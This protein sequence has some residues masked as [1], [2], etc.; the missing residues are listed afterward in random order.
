MRSMVS[1]D[2]FMFLYPRETDAEV[3]SPRTTRVAV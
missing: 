3:T 1:L 2:D